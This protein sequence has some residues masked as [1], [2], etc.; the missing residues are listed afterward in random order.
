MVSAFAL[1]GLLVGVAGDALGLDPDHIRMAGAVLLMAF[2]VVMLTPP[3]KERFTHLMAPMATGAHNASS[4]FH[5][6]SLGGAFMVGGL[7]GMVWSPLLGA[8][9]DQC[10]DD[11]RH[12][13]GRDP[14]DGG[15]GRFWLGCG[16]R[17]GGSRLR[18]PRR[19]RTRSWLGHG[20]YGPC[21]A[22]LRCVGAAAWSRTAAVS[23]SKLSTTKS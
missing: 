13:E 15:A 5:T 16:H 18:L 11:R 20:E 3:L 6:G 4:R 2:G 8:H 22:W 1:L 12:R 10:L 9:A 19:F 21:Q 17:T 14:R 23:S 7:L